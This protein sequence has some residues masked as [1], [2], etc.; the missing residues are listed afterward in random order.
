MAVF[1]RVLHNVIPNKEN[2]TVN[3]EWPQRPVAT[4]EQDVVV[5]KNIT[6]KQMQEPFQAESFFSVSM[7]LHHG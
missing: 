1:Y 3:Y 4:L 5:R 6:N 7:H 2:H